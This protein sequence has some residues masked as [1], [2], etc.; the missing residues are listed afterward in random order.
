M[1]GS[2]FSVLVLPHQTERNGKE[3]ETKSCT[4][5]ATAEE[6]KNFIPESYPILS[7]RQD[8]EIKPFLLEKG[9]LKKISWTLIKNIF[10]ETYI[11]Y[12]LTKVSTRIIDS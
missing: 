12:T 3:R 7:N 1:T 10:L 5:T 6:I 4:I 8:T 11:T 2:I 9:F